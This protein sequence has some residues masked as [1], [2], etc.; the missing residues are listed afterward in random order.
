MAS[1]A[2]IELTILNYFQGKGL[3]RQAAAGIVG[4]V[5]QE[6]S[7]NPNAPGGGLFQGQAGR[8][9]AGGTLQQ[10]LNAVWRELSTE[11]IGVLH[12]L[13]RASTPEEAAKIFE[14]GFEEA[15]EPNMPRREAIAH[16]AFM[17]QAAGF[18]PN[19]GPL[20]IFGTQKEGE[21]IAE[22]GVQEAT[23]IIKGPVEAGKAAAEL[24]KVLLDPKTWL[25]I[26]EGLGGIVL[27]YMGLSAL[28]RTG[29]APEVTGVVRQA[30]AGPRKVAKAAA[31]A[32]AV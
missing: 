18:L 16:Q 24:V 32:A 7:F 29:K 12:Q 6:S 31:A 28:T 25:R 10:Q 27:I 2:D 1:T 21:K 19:L 5:G 17:G 20:D 26:A 3:S 9:G 15:G 23:G 14:L 22:E 11:R 8:A 13:Q 30:S 4:N